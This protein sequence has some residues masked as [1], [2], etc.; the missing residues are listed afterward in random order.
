MDLEGRLAT[1]LP[2]GDFIKRVPAEQALPH[3]SLLP[4][5]A[6]GLSAWGRAQTSEINSRLLPGFL[7]DTLHLMPNGDRSAGHFAACSGAQ[8]IPNAR[9]LSFPVHASGLPVGRK[10][11]LEPDGPEGCFDKELRKAVLTFRCVCFLTCEMGAAGDPR[12]VS[13]GTAC[14]VCAVSLACDVG[15]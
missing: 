1:H 12:P 6:A 13:K 5:Q 4:C 9:Q 3:A 2:A 10:T 8:A 15:F 11:S 7:E 14:G